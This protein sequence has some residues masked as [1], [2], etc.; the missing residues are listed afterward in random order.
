MINRPS[1]SYGF[2][3]HFTTK[4]WIALV[5]PVALILM[6]MAAF[7]S[8]VDWLGH[9]LGYLAAFTLYWV[10]W[11]ICVPL[12]LLR[13]AG[14]VSIFQAGPIKLTKLGWKTHLLLWWSIPFPLFFIFISKFSSITPAILVV[15]IL[16]GIMIAVTE[17]ALWRGVYVRLFPGNIWLDTLYPSLM[18]ALL[19]VAPQIVRTNTLPGGMASFILYALVLGLSYA[20]YARKTGSIRWCTISHA[21][22]DSLG[23]GALAYAVWLIA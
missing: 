2:R 10:G 22:H 18:F 23:L 3:F 5:L 4:Q 6:M 19:H 14:F 7:R 15:S 9:P 21:I 1:L 12:F 13:P 20:Y 17:E 11:G 16:I 8:F